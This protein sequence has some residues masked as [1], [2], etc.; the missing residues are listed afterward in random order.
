MPNVSEPLRKG[1]FIF[2]APLI[3][4]ALQL[5]N[6]S[7]YYMPKYFCVFKGYVVNPGVPV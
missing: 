3:H 4:R 6:V 1:K 5:Y 2:I 7:N